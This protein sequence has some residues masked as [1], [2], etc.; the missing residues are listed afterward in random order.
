MQDSIGAQP[1][2]RIVYV[3]DDESLSAL[4]LFFS[5][6]GYEIG[7][8]NQ[9]KN[10]DIGLIDLRGK[11]VSS[12]KAQSIAAVLR[13]SSPELSILMLVDPFVDDTARKALRRHGELVVATT[14]MNGVIERCRQILRVRNIAEE[15]GERLKTLAT[16]N[17]LNEFPPISATTA[18][19]KVLV[20]G[21]ASPLALNIL[22]ALLPICEQCICVFSAGQALRALESANFDAAMFLPKSGSDPLMSLVRSLRRHPK[23]A[24]MPVVFPIDD[25]D[26]CGDLALRGATDFIFANHIATDL[27]PKIQVAAR[28]AR[29]MM[30]MRKFLQACEGDGIRD[31]SSGAF[32]ATFLAEHGARLCSRSDQSGRSMALIALKIG[33]ASQFNGEAEP[34]RRALHQA[35]RLIN[36]VSRAEDVVCRIATDIFL[37][38]MPATTEHHASQ[39]AQRIQGVLENTVFRSNSENMLY[40]M[41]VALAIRSRPEGMCVEECV[42]MILSS[43]RVDADASASGGR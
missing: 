13:K 29:L 42:A 23:H 41:T 34:G 18:P 39:A 25:P 21:E 36:R 33:S 27:G 35:A 1:K 6:S 3:G 2:A 32:T 5:D 37:I 12:R 28:R 24:S 20:A 43:L 7:P 11:R 22:N 19:L 10:G 26:S 38:L 30:T 31:P 14:S 8:L 9:L 15:T 17:R 40:G 4:T 16:L